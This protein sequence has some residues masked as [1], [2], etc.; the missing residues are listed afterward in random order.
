MQEAPDLPEADVVQRSLARRVVRGL[1]AGKAQA[2]RPLR[3]QSA[4]MDRC[5][6]T[7]AGKNRLRTA[8]RRTRRLERAANELAALRTHIGGATE[9]GAA[10]RSML[11][12]RRAAFP[13]FA[14]PADS[15]GFAAEVLV[16]VGGLAAPY[17]AC[18]QAEA[19]DVAG[20]RPGACRSRHG[21]V[22]PCR[23]DRAC[24][25][26]MLSTSCGVEAEKQLPIW[27][28]LARDLLQLSAN[29]CRRVVSRVCNAT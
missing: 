8:A 15:E 1:G 11:Q 2:G 25:A 24:R 27:S 12:R 4:A 23:A 29:E 14:R 9:P 26:Q 16:A 13:A 21:A 17:G 5:R 19:D 28:V 18:S 10:V 7:W 6:H 20:G 3:V 22:R